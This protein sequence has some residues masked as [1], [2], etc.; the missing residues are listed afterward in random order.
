[1]ASDDLNVTVINYTAPA[2][3]GS[4]IAI[5]CG[6]L[7]ANNYT[8]TCTERRWEPSLSQISTMCKTGITKFYPCS[9][10]LYNIKLDCIMLAKCTSFVKT[11][12]VIKVHASY[13]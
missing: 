10:Y 11:L 5:E 1:M 13:I 7:S 3:E 12:R 9:G 2:L 6:S 8:S 4:I